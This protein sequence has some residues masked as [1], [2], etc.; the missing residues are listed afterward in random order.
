MEEALPPPPSGEG[1]RQVAE[2]LVCVHIELPSIPLRGSSAHPTGPPRCQTL[3]ILLGSLAWPSWMTVVAPHMDPVPA[4]SA[5]CF[6]VACGLVSPDLRAT[7]SLVPLC[8]SALSTGPG[9]EQPWEC[10][11]G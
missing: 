6:V 7:W 3:S 2:A 1:E 11:C 9:L 5:A 4:Y 8:F 10:T